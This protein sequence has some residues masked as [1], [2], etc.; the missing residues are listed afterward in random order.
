VWCLHR[1]RSSSPTSTTPPTASH[2]QRPSK[3]YLLLTRQ[4]HITWCRLATHPSVAVIPLLLFSPNCPQKVS[5]CR[6]HQENLTTE[7]NAFRLDGMDDQKVATRLQMVLYFQNVMGYVQLCLRFSQNSHKLT[8]IMSSFLMQNFTQIAS[9]GGQNGIEIHLYP[10]VKHTLHCAHTKPTITKQF[11]CGHPRNFTDTGR[12]KSGLFYIFKERR[13]LTAN[14]YTEL[15]IAE[16]LQETYTS[17]KTMGRK[18]KLWTSLH[19]HP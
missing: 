3:L 2:P 9:N 1:Q 10:L 11:F 8:I 5:V 12:R 19:L 18:I 16:W 6:G 17:F 7:I 4:Q 14:T 15:T 13:L